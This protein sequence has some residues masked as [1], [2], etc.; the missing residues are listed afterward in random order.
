MAV[1]A[2]REASECVLTNLFED[3]YLLSLHAKRVTLFPTDIA[4]VLSLRRDGLTKK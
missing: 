3:A 1:E 4:L 2:L